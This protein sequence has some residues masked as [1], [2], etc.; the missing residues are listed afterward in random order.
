MTK[1]ASMKRREFTYEGRRYVLV[2]L[3][4]DRRLDHVLDLVQELVTNANLPA[5]GGMIELEGCT[6]TIQHESK[7]G[8]D[9][10]ALVK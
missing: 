5:L 10:L 7:G 2:A 8:S 3:G 4:E 6:V 1:E 9:E